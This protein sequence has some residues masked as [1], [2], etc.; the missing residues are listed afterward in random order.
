MIVTT[1]SPEG[2]IFKTK[3][4]IVQ[5]LDD[6]Q[7]IVRDARPKY[8]QD[9]EVGASTPSRGIFFGHEYRPVLEKAGYLG[10]DVKFGYFRS[11]ENN[12]AVNQAL[13]VI[14]HYLGE[15]A[16]ILENAKFHPI[17]RQYTESDLSRFTLIHGGKA[18]TV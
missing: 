17:T 14:E 8:F 6:L 15:I 7:R 11:N 5:A 1:Y 13:G 18:V 10:C 9:K 12:H 3:S 4:G 2:Y 16:E